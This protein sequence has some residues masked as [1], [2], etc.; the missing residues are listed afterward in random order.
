M[1]RSEEWY[2]VAD[3]TAKNWIELVPSIINE[4]I[5]FP[6][7]C[8]KNFINKV[9]L[10]MFS[11][12]LLQFHVLFLNPAN[13]PNNLLFFSLS[14]LLTS[15]DQPLLKINLFLYFWHNAKSTMFLRKIVS[16]TPTTKRDSNFWFDV[17]KYCII[18]WTSCFRSANRIKILWENLFMEAQL[19][20]L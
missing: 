14:Y 9:Y 2:F 5:L 11:F 3:I 19:V 15:V 13:L 20:V 1:S 6:R 10:E 16:I 17:P 4:E 8:Y 7:S 12:H 18:L